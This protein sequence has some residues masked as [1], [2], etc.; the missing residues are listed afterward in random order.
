MAAPDTTYRA[1]VP[2]PLSDTGAFR[3]DSLEAPG[4]KAGDGPSR[5]RG[6]LLM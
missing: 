4:G 6:H 1:R 5:F 3:C 2:T